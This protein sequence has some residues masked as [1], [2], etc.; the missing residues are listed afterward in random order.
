M[1]DGIAG[2]ARKILAEQSIEKDNLDGIK[3]EA[4]YVTINELLICGVS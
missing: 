4:R 2:Q 3:A 1:N